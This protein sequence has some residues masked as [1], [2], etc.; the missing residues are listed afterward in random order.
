MKILD[1]YLLRE[2]APPFLFGVLAFVL[3][4]VSA[5]VLFKLT[6]L[7]SELGISLWTATIL[8]VLWLPEF[9]IYTFPLA[10][11]VA[12]L[13]A[14]GRLSGDS[15]LV[16][17]HAGGVSFRRLVVPIA[18][19]GLLVSLL[20]LAL[21]EFVVPPCNRTSESILRLASEQA[22][23]AGQQQVFLKDV[24]HG[25]VVRL[26]YADRLDLETEEMTRPTITWFEE[27]RPVMVTVAE[28]G[29]WRGS[30]WEMLDGVNYGI[31]GDWLT[32]ERFQR[33]TTEFATSPRMIAQQARSPREMTYRE[34]REYIRLAIHQQ[35]P[36]AQLELTLHHKVSL[37]FACLVF[38]LVA[39]PLGMRAHRGSSA[40]GMGL[41][42]L[43]GFAYYVVW[44][45]LS[46][47]AQQGALAPLWAAWLPNIAFAVVGLALILRVRK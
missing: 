6:Q 28:R 46:I 45:Y 43:L 40:I 5:N 18:I 34:L 20:T 4:F 36:T 2:V 23:K 33:W 22:G 37:P 21:G 39:P 8:F 35:R 31:G 19:M 30:K 25:Q 47:L 16:A 27:G 29:R 13:I 1:R 44:N 32:S 12:I 26:V 3:L 14:F 17:M 10:T 11:L 15:E 38:A 24:S 9:A 41:A 7:I 42:I